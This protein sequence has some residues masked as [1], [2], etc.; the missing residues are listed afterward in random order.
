MKKTIIFAL[1]FT[2]LLFS[3]TTYAQNSCRRVHNFCTASLPEEENSKD[4][5][6]DNQSK[7][8][9][10]EKGKTYEMSFVAYENYV[11]RIATCTDLAVSEKIHFEVF[12]N[13]LVRKPLN[14]VNR[15][16][17]EKM[18]IYDNK[19][20]NMSSFYKFRVDKSEKIY[21]KVSIPSSG[22]SSNKQ[23]KDSEFVCVG[24]L[25]QKRRAAKTGF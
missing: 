1:A 11:Y 18:P 13:V 21:V 7:S 24:V 4:W 15:L 3:Q 25:L 16:V 9:T 19:S 14:G 23:L 17:K 6:F 22:E 2:G 5:M 20:D 12:H 10:F 8:A